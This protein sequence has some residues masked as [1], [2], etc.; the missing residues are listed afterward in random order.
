MA[1]FT[2]LVRNLIEMDFKFFVCLLVLLSQHKIGVIA[3]GKSN[4]PFMIDCT[5]FKKIPCPSPIRPKHVLDYVET[6]QT[7]VLKFAM[8]M[9][10][11]EKPNGEEDI[12]FA[13]DFFIKDRINTLVN[14]FDMYTKYQQ[15]PDRCTVNLHYNAENVTSTDPYIFLQCDHR[16]TNCSVISWTCINSEE[17]KDRTKILKLVDEVFQPVNPHNTTYFILMVIVVLL[18]VFSF[19]Y[20]QIFVKV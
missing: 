1:L 5:Q 17:H 16:L 8:E 14:A 9:R 12:F 7:N 4:E 13:M 6:S 3:I 10:S 20:I 15:C 11:C 2:S 18:S 19:V